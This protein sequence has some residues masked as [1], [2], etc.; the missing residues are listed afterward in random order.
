MVK[1]KDIEMFDGKQGCGQISCH[2]KERNT[3]SRSKVLQE[4]TQAV[5]N[6]DL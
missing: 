2:N 3:G 6:D 5:F 1:G 4:I